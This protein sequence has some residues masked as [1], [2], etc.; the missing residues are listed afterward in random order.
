MLNLFGH[1]WLFLYS[2]FSIHHAF[3][4]EIIPILS[5]R[6]YKFVKKLHKNLSSHVGWIS[7]NELKYHSNDFFMST[8]QKSKFFVLYWEFGIMT[9]LSNLLEA[10]LDVYLY[11]QAGEYQ[12][13]LMKV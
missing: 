8:A 11:I 9:W 4:A 1:F 6:R 12:L 7:T 13:I 2:A 3:N 10:C 5:Q